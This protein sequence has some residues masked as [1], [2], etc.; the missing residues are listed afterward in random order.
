MAHTTSA[1]VWG[2][3]RF[4]NSRPD[5]GTFRRPNQSGLWQGEQRAL[6]D[7]FAVSVYAQDMNGGAD[8]KTINLPLRD[9]TDRIADMP[10]VAAKTRLA[11][12]REKGIRGKQLGRNG[13]ER[14]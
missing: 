7:G 11:L 6:E 3:T 13:N 9:T 14:K 1:D 8:F 12:G 5:L 10:M 4:G 2:D